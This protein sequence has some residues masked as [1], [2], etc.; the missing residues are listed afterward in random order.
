MAN[1]IITITNYAPE[2]DKVYKEASL[3]AVL[4]SNEHLVRLEGKEFKI[5]KMEMDGLANHDRSGGGVYVEGGVTLEWVT[6]TP[7]YDRNRKFTVDAMDDAETRGLAF[8]QL[9]GEFIRTKTVPELDA[10]R[11]AKYATNAG[12]T[13]A[14]DLADGK[15]VLAAIREA[16]N[17]F[18]EGE[19]PQDDR[20]L[21]ITPTNLNVVMD[22]QTIE[23]RAALDHFEGRIVKVPQTRFVT[24]VDLN[25]GKTAGQEAGGW[26]KATDAKDI[27]FIVIHRPAIIQAL[28]H[29]APKYIPASLNQ[30]ADGDA[31]AYR[32]YGVAE[33][34]DNKKIG[35]YAHTKE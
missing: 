18:D 11:F 6:K 30:T 31:Y 15:A 16:I 33:F 20:W 7:D 35:I 4:D 3:T 34:F 27:N 22:L 32:V 5:P 24:A 14:E 28:K 12:T 26:A 17:V 25:D 8:G 29:V 19:V 1:S 21:F 10:V 2:L 23:S 9:S 13:K